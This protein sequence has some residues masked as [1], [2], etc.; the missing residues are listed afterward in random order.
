MLLFGLYR[1]FPTPFYSRTVYIVLAE[2]RFDKCYM[3][4]TAP[5]KWVR[6]VFGTK[7]G[8]ERVFFY[9]VVAWTYCFSLSLFFLFLF[10]YSCCMR[11]SILLGWVVLAPE[12]ESVRFA[13]Q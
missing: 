5:L 4:W 6:P 11:L 1:C 2:W 3:L 7:G 13:I 8:K 12:R 10:L 9:S